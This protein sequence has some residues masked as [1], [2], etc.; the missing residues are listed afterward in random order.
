MNYKNIKINYKN[1]AKWIV[2]L[3][4]D[5]LVFVVLGLLL[6]NYDDFYDESKGEY[7]SFGSMTTYQKIIDISFNVWILL[8]CFFFIKLLWSGWIKYKK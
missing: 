2:V 4:L 8:N 3:I 7:G 5:C 1:I 6:M